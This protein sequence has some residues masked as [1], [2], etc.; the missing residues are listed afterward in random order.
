VAGCPGKQVVFSPKRVL[1]G[2]AHF[3]DGMAAPRP[4]LRRKKFF[5]NRCSVLLAESPH[6][7]Q[8]LP[9]RARALLDNKPSFSR[10]PPSRDG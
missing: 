4:R 3:G 5:G 1:L 9:P 8:T 10:M 7:A 2:K 6:L